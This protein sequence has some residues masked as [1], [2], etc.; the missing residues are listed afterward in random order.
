MQWTAASRCTEDHRLV[1]SQPSGDLLAVSLPGIANDV[2]SVGYVNIYAWEETQARWIWES[3]TMDGGGTRFGEALAMGGSVEEPFLVIGDP[4]Y[5][6]DAL[7]E[8]QGRLVVLQRTPQEAQEDGGIIWDRW[9]LERT[10]V[11]GGARIGSSLT[12]TPDGRMFAAGSSGF[13]ADL[14]RVDVWSFVEL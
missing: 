8:K 9:L 14:G 10:G 3:G 6:P 1:L 2:E 13:D 7:N 11:G 12:M 5:S 4:G